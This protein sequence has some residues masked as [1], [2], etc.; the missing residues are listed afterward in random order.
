EQRDFPW[1]RTR[2]PWSVLV[3]EVMLQQTQA[4]RVAERFGAFMRRFPTAAAMAAG[5]DAEVLAAWSGLGYNRRAV[6]LR[7]AAIMVDQHGW[8]HDVAGLQDL[9]G[10][11]PYTARAVAALA[12]GRPVGAVDTNVRRW[13][14]RRLG[15]ARDASSSSLQAVAD[16][17]AADAPDAD[18]AAAWMHA[19]MEFGAAVCRARNPD[20][21]ACPVADG[22]PSRGRGVAVPVARQPTFAGSAREA[23]GLLLKALASAPEHRLPMAEVASIVSDVDLDRL[24]PGLERDGLAHRS[25]DLVCLGG[26]ESDGGA[27]ATIGT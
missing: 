6:A 7:R 5:S 1:R 13:L 8:P 26:R 3:S 18:Q 27:V 15:M 10:I 17:L 24:L 20:C 23:R 9:P 11:G 21:E 22:C 16:A 25:D 12:F 2:D 4:H 19:S 14:V